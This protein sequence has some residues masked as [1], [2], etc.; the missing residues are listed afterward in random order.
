MQTG[1]NGLEWKTSSGAR[2]VHLNTVESSR[3]ILGSRIIWI[4]FSWT[5][6]VNDFVNLLVGSLYKPFEQW[7]EGFGVRDTKLKPTI[8]LIWSEKRESN[9]SV[10]E[11][12]SLRGKSNTWRKETLSSQGVRGGQVKGVNSMEF[13]RWLTNNT[14]LIVLALKKS[15]VMGGWS[16]TQ[17]E[18]TPENDENLVGSSPYG[19]RLKGVKIMQLGEFK[20]RS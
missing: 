11:T 6:F 7:F 16:T 15:I 20:R 8:L 12:Q 10:T 5:S 17:R 19:E 2:C 18:S 13:I 4:E 9:D 1:R 14:S 3:V